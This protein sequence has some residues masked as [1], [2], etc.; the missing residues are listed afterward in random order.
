MNAD[1]PFC[2]VILD[3]DALNGT[4]GSLISMIPA[5]PFLHT[6]F[7]LAASFLRLAKRKTVVQE[8]YCIEMLA[9]VDTLCLDKTGTI[10]DGTMR[11][12]DSID[13]RSGTHSYT[14]REIVSS[15]N[16]AL[17]ADN[18][19]SKALKKFFGCPKNLRCRQLP[20]F[21]F[22][23][24]VNFPPFPSRGRAPTFWVRRNTS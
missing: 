19:T 15:M 24:S 10:T 11:V 8:L 6:S 22:H 18:K 21:R 1:V 3:I 5:G 13:L 16:V 12:E 23:L 4:A 9:R 20:Q 7:A 17:Q 14:V 2:F